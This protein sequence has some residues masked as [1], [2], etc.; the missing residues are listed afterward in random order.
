MIII[1]SFRY[2][3]FHSL[4]INIF[5]CIP[6]VLFYLIPCYLTHCFHASFSSLQPLERFNPFSTL[7]LIIC[8]RAAF[9]FSSLI[10]VPHILVSPLLS[11]VI[12][13]YLRHLRRWYHCFIFTFV[14]VYVSYPLLLFGFTF[15]FIL[16]CNLFVLHCVFAL[17]FP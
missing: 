1:L 13:L 17:F 6:R 14:L 4:F 15:F 12:A 3:L 5:P 8:F 7:S 11:A 2:L 10:Y 16:F 9:K